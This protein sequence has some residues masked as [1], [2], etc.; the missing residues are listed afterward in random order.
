MAVGL[1]SSLAAKAGTDGVLKAE[2]GFCGHFS[3]AFPCLAA[4]CLLRVLETRRGV[5]VLSATDRVPVFL[6]GV[7]FCCVC[8][9]LKSSSSAVL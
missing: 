1:G 4:L 7:V 6:T 8:M 2:L 5:S 3:F 9:G